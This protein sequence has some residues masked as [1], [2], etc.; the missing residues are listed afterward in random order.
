MR[1]EPVDDAAILCEIAPAFVMR[2]GARTD[3]IVLACTHYPFLLPQFARLAPWP[4]TWIDPAPAIARRAAVVLRR[5]RCR[6]G[7]R[8]WAGAA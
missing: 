4:V 8:R 7:P 3:V 6:G 5:R 2:D 1:G